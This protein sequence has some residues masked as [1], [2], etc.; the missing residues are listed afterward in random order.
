MESALQIAEGRLSQ[1]KEGELPGYGRVMGGIPSFALPAEA[2]M[3]RSDMSAAANILLKIR[4][5]AAVTESENRRFLTEIASGAG[6]D[7]K[8]LRHGW[9]NVRRE[10]EAKKG[11]ILAQADDATLNTY[12]ERAPIE[13][14]RRRSTDKAPA[15][16]PAS[17]PKNIS[18][19]Y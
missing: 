7:E 16:T 17:A 19:D 3:A 15:A 18:V 1:H 6:M 13:M 11:N 8:A 5:G 4:S 14:R 9:E 10:F 2:Q 12:N